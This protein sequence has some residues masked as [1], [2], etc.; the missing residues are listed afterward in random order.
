MAYSF[1]VQK[2]IPMAQ[3]TPDT[4][5]LKLTATNSNGQHWNNLEA[6]SILLQGLNLSGGLFEQATACEVLPVPIE[7]DACS[8][9]TL[10]YVNKPDI[11]TAPE[12]V[13][14]EFE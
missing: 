7:K 12:Q 13:H 14:P 8:K 3:H 6:A 2:E 4:T 9:H 10:S 5:A 1:H 11:G